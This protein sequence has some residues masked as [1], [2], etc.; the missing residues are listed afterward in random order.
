[1]A[2]QP[3]TVTYAGGAPGLVAG[4]MQVNVQIP[5]N[6]V[7][8]YQRPGCGSRGGL[9]SGFVPDQPNVTITVSQS[10]TPSKP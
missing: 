5:A 3:V 4:V 9:K 2:G 8:P 1:M 10:K 7:R 6:L